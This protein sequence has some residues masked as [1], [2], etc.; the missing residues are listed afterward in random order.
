[1]HLLIT[2][3]CGFVGSSIAKF[4]LSDHHSAEQ[5]GSAV[6]R[7]AVWP[8]KITLVD[9][10]IRPGSQTNQAPLE[11][12][13]AQV[14]IG[15]LRNRDFV[16]NLPRSD[17]VIDC[18]ANP[19]VLAG[20]DTPKVTSAS[21]SASLQLV[22]HNLGSTIHLL[23][24]CKRHACGLVLISTSRVYSIQK[25]QSIPYA[26]DNGSLAVCWENLESSTPI[27]GLSRYGI[28]EAFSVEPPLSLYGTTKLASEWLAK[29]Y[30]NAF[31]FPLWIN[32][33]GILAGAGQFGKADQGI[34][35]YW[36]HRYLYQHPLRFIGYQGTGAQVR[37]CL[38]P[39]DLARLIQLQIQHVGN[40]QPTTVN[41]SGG[42]ESAFSL[43]DLHHWCQERWGSDRKTTSPKPLAHREPV[44]RIDQNRPF[45][46][47]WIVLDARVAQK[48]WNWSAQRNSKSIWEEIAEHAQENPNWLHLSGGLE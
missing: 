29:E 30:S 35:T 31:G 19:S 46:A 23:E 42:I 38:H 21:P 20:L 7:S 44:E 11:R 43:Q 26:I 10:L 9:N 15:D 48:H 5:K 33:C 6:D 27:S 18:A 40:N 8:S 32:R 22:D 2:G 14:I 28:S 37:D 3:G 39:K 24:Y 36:I 47:P 45:D 12:L 16:N 34:I 17:W 1:M 4:F 25:L 41:V 13:G